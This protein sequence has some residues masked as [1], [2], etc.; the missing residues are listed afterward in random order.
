MKV[1]VISGS[2][3]KESV[4][5]HMMRFVYEHTKSKG[6]DVKFLNLSEGGIDYF[7]G[8]AEYSESTKQAVR[9]L[10][11]ADV[12]LV[13]TPIFNSFF[14]SAL[15]NLFEFLNYKETPGKVAGLAIMA[16]GDISFVYVQTLLSQMMSYF[17]I[18]TNPKA[19]YMKAEEIGDD[20]KPTAEAQKR[21]V[22]MVDR[23]LDVA[24]RVQQS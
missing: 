20:H 1:I 17:G 23:T 22:E 10:T 15:K 5:Q 2:P 18:M 13:G 12:W 6:T 11:E 16:S 7:R 14:S 8:D 21:L 3:R 9:D 24:S 4:T 19:V